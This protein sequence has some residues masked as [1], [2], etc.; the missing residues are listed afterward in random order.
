MNKKNN[1]RKRKKRKQDNINFSREQIE[2][3]LINL[4]NMGF[5]ETKMENGEKLFKLA[6]NK[7]TKL[8]NKFLEEVESEGMLDDIFDGLNDGL[9]D[10]VVEKKDIFLRLIE[11]GE[12]FQYNKNA[13]QTKKDRG[14]FS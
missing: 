14:L 7:K 6:N 13:R 11:T 5:V 9:I 2:G 10:I 4:V 1:K 12:L 8:L 3:D